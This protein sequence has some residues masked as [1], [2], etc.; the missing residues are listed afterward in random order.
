MI[1]GGGSPFTSGSCGSAHVTPLPVA[2]HSRA[3]CPRHAVGWNSPAHPSVGS[4]SSRPY[5][6]HRTVLARPTAQSISASRFAENTPAREPNHRFPAGSSSTCDS[7]SL[8]SPCA[9]VTA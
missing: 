8:G 5:I 9:A 3:S 1:T 2:N 7:V 6:R 4:P